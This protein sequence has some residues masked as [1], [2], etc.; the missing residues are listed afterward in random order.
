MT[1]PKANSPSDS[2]ATEVGP[3]TFMG[4]EN[5]L[6]LTA[7]RFRRKDMNILQ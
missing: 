2:V 1:L 3:I 4:L 6:I 5:I 7:F